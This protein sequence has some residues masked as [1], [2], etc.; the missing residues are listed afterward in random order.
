MGSK[1]N[2][3]PVISGQHRG[4]FLLPGTDACVLLNP[5]ECTL[6][7]LFLNHPEGIQAKSLTA[8]WQELCTLYAHESIFDDKCLMKSTMQSLCDNSKVVFS[9]NVSRIKKKFI[10]ALGTRKAAPYIIKRGKD[11]IYRTM[12]TW[13]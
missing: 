1:R 3:H 2:H 7:R 6:Y 12:A 9:A 10:A 4:S 13:G 11:G 5:V 8:H